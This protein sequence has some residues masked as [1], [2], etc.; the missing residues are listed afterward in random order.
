MTPLTTSTQNWSVPAYGAV[1]DLALSDAAL[2]APGEGEVAV[3]IEAASVNPFDLKLLSGQL[4]DFVPLAFPF[5]SGGDVAGRIIG[6]GN[7][8]TGYKVGDRVVGLTFK[9]GTV[10]RHIVLPANDS[11]AHIPDGL[12]SGDA[13]AL[14]EAA[15]TAVALL[16]GVGDVS[17]KTLAIIGATGGIG[18]FLIQLAQSA[19]ATVI[20]TAGPDDTALV[21]A[22]G[23]HET[24]DYNTTDT[25][26]ALKAR[27]PEG[28]DAIIDLVTQFAPLARTAEAIK[29]GGALASPLFGPDPDSFPR[30]IKASY[31]RVSAQPGDLAVLV[32]D[33]AS[34]KLKANVT[35]RVPFANAPE[36]YRALRD[37][38]VQGKI[39]ILSNTQAGA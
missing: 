30:G 7:G 14:P 29:D 20:A 2:T 24:I 10:A 17:G 19:G 4:K 18:L 16:R 35:K 28:V 15:L 37:D 23:A 25:I 6:V 36:A 21:I 22:N 3:E 31:I 38:H 1:E 33:L 39:V 13:A 8:V 5:A 26:D 9:H 12:D 27:Y 11:L 32:A 34:G